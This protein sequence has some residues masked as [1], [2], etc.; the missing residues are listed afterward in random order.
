MLF[1]GDQQGRGKALPVG[2]PANRLLQ[3]AVMAEKAQQL[4]RVERARHRPEPCTRS[5]GQND[6]VDHVTSSWPKGRTC[7]TF[8]EA[9]A[10]IHRFR[11][12]ANPASSCKRKPKGRGRRGCCGG[13]CQNPA[14]RLAWKRKNKRGGGPKRSPSGG[15]T[16]TAAT[17]RTTQIGRAAAKRPN[18]KL[19]AL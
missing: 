1:I 14:G 2:N 16:K 11:N 7:S 10:D 5:A 12:A 6:G 9:L 18:G 15:A 13:E 19:D 3:Q 17:A 8:A 4:F